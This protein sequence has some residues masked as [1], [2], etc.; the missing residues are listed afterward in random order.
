MHFWLRKGID[1]FRIDVVNMY[2]KAPGL[3]DAPITN[4]NSPYQMDVSLFCNGPRMG[5]YLTEMQSV[6]SQYGV[7]MTVGELPATWDRAGLL[8][9]VSA[10]AKQLNMVFQFDVVGVG[11]PGLDDDLDIAPGDNWAVPDLAKAVANTQNLLRDSDGWTTVFL[12]NHDQARSVSRWGS[13][14]T[15]ESRVRSAKLL[16][17]LCATLSGTLFIYQGQEIGM[18]NAPPSWTIEEYKD[19]AT[20]NNYNEKK[21]ESGGDPKVL[22]YTMASLQRLAR[23]HSR[24]PFSWNASPNA[25]FTIDGA[26]PWM[27]VHDNHR[28]VKAKQQIADKDSV[29]SF[30]KRVLFLRKKYADVL[31]HGIYEPVLDQHA[32]VYM[33]IKKGTKRSTIVALNFS[34]K[35]QTMTL[36]AAVSTSDLTL[37][38]SSYGDYVIDKL[39]SF[40]AVVWLTNK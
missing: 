23:D 13:D 39:R 14:A 4:K 27:R 5:H 28:L 32:D 6:L 30:W 7:T 24:I 10:A 1:G 3:P 40:E 37:V 35:E 9:Y 22:A 38:I 26:K 20:I 36:P 15:E 29:L 8:R 18:V 2:D 16:A 34:N 31:V 19:V 17:T 12:E 11:R 33:Y 25:G 21:Q